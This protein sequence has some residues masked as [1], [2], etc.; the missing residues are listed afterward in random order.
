MQ[1][2]LLRGEEPPQPEGGS[3]RTTELPAPLPSVVATS[4][5]ICSTVLDSVK[6]MLLGPFI[7]QFIL[8][9]LQVAA[10]LAYLLNCLANALITP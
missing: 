2:Q 3:S 10:M 9:S 6:L 5:I 7:Q 1:P 4:R 8:N